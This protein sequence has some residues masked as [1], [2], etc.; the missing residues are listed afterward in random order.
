MC[1]V[2]DLIFAHSENGDF[3]GKELINFEK[4]AEI[5]YVK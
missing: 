1:F 3:I 4:P 2:E 5:F